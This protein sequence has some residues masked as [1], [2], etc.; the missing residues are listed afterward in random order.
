IGRAGSLGYLQ[1]RFDHAGNAAS[2]FVLEV[3]DVLERAVEPIGPEMRAGFGIDQL[4]CDPHPVA[5]LAHR[6]FE[7]V[8]YA[9]FARD[10]LHLDRLPLVGEARIARDYEKPANTGERGDD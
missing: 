8:A 3:E 2:H 10:T 9:K 4:P 1:R 7:H 5:G 6:A